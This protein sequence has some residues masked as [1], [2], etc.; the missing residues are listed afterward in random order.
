MESD[1]SH[2]IK[3][4]LLRISDSLGDEVFGNSKVAQMLGCSETTATSY[5]K[6]MHE[7]LHIISPVDGMG[8]G[9]Y[10]FNEGKQ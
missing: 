4:R 1:Y 6:K 3:D 10:I 8:K 7:E 2:L 5:I 9:K